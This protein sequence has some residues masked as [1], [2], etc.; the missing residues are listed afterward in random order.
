MNKNYVFI[1]K[2]RHSS[3]IYLKKLTIVNSICLSYFHPKCFPSC[4]LPLK[5]VKN[6]IFVSVNEHL[7]SWLAWE[8]EGKKTNRTAH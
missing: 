4:F 7:N 3:L 5:V 8:E 1:I 2:V 6:G